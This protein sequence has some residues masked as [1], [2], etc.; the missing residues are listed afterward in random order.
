[1]LFAPAAPLALLAGC[2]GGGN[3]PTPLGTPTSPT[4]TPTP[5]PHPDTYADPNPDPDAYPHAN[6]DT[7]HPTGHRRFTSPATI[8]LT[9][10]TVRSHTVTAT[11]P[12]GDRR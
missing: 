10:N 5:T 4:P 6:A 7:P 2:S 12:D 8:N 3:T 1:M 9:E 11:D